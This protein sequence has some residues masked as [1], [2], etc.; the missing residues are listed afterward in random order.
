MQNMLRGLR[1]SQ[2]LWFLMWAYFQVF[3]AVVCEENDATERNLSGG[4]DITDQIHKQE[5]AV[6]IEELRSVLAMKTND[7]QREVRK[8]K[9]FPKYW[10][11]KPAAVKPDPKPVG[12][13]R[14]SIKDDVEVL[15]D[16]LIQRIL[17]D[18]DSKENRHENVNTSTPNSNFKRCAPSKRRAPSHSARRRNS[19]KVNLMNHTPDYDGDRNDASKDNSDYRITNNEADW[20]D[21]IGIG[22]SASL[23]MQVAA[24]A[25]KRQEPTGFELM[26]SEN[27]D[28]II[29]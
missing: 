22:F 6:V 11:G 21:G 26:T 3:E 25:R 17:A 14:K 19:K 15:L 9:L 29:S 13:R 18:M 4:E 16:S 23:A 20:S 10:A 27:T 7:Q 12:K 8:R 1:R 5:S 24:M 2:L 28:D